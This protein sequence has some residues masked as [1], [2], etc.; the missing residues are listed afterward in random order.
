MRERS[1]SGFELFTDLVLGE[2]T[3]NQCF[4]ELFT[5]QSRFVA[6]FL[7]SLTPFASQIVIHPKLI[8]WFV[9]DVCAP[10]SA[11]LPSLTLN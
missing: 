2:F 9:S 8:P 3:L 11:S 1:Q 7:L 10:L 5:K 4:V 6:D